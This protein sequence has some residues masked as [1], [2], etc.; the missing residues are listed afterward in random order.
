MRI[1]TI[2]SHISSNALPC[3]QRNKT[4]FGY[5]V[6]DIVSSLAAEGNEVDV[7]A[8]WY[9]YHPLWLGGAHYLGCSFWRIFCNVVYLIP[10]SSFFSLIHKYP[11]SFGA[12][13]RLFYCWLLTGYY[14]KVLKK[15]NYDLVHIHGCGLNEEMW[16]QLCKRIGQKCVVTLHGLNSFNDTVTIENSVKRYERDFLHRVVQGEVHITVIASGIKKRILAVENLNSSK[17]IDVVCNSF[18]F[19]EGESNGANIRERY[20]IPFSMKIVLYVG[21]ISCNK[22]QRQMV[23]SFSYLRADLRENTFILFIGNP[24]DE[25][26]LESQI[27][28]SP[29]SSHMRFIGGVD[30]AFIPVF[31]KEA[32]ATALLSYS[33]GF[34]LSIAEGMHFGL[35]GMMFT[36][37]DA[38]DDLYNPC[39]LVGIEKRSNEDVAKALET[40]LTNVW[41]KESIKS[42]STKFH[43]KGM[44]QGYLRVFRSVINDIS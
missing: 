13:I 41:D 24:S 37:M 10:F 38:Y 42:F 25:F 29:Y 12:T 15:G 1:L 28:S 17:Y 23:E 19:I 16:V 31:Y 34:G 21:N 36:D 20:Q 43:P 3:F 2:T 9:R 27:K 39:A 33:E 18:H 30:K 6:Q 35:P 26:D 7:L 5:M 14:R 40:L 4:G 22:N 8:S 11:V 44:A 32:V